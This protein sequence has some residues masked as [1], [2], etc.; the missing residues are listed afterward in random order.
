MTALADHLARVGLTASAAR[1]AANLV[2]AAF[3]GLQLDQPLDSRARQQRTVRDL[4]DSVAAR[5]GPLETARSPVRQ[6][7]QP[8]SA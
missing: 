5:W 4:A 2:D 7:G 3:M 6:D 8:G 1:Q